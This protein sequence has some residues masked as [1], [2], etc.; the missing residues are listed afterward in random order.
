MAELP[1][2]NCDGVTAKG[3][4]SDLLHAFQLQGRTWCYSDLADDGGFSV[5]PNDAVLVHA[6]VHGSIR[7]VRAGQPPL[8]VDAG[9]AV[10]VLSGEAHALRTAV[11]A[12]ADGHGYLRKE[13]NADIPASFS[14][15]Q[16]RRYCARVLSGRMRPTWPD[17]LSRSTLPPLLHLGTGGENTTGTVTPAALVRYGFGDGSPVVL[18]QLASFLLIEA[19]RQTRLRGNSISPAQS[20]PIEEA[21]QAIR[22]SPGN[23]WTV[24]QLAQRVGMRRSNFSAQ[25]TARIGRPP[26]EFVTQARMEKAA[27]LLCRSQMAIADIGEAIGYSCEAAFVR[28]FT[29]YFSVAPTHMRATEASA[30]PDESVSPVPLAILKGARNTEARMVRHAVRDPDNR[31]PYDPLGSSNM[32]LR[33]R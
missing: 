10:A 29:R 8:R 23:D 27:E 21:V 14:F 11:D 28:R 3:S 26:M 1:A 19:L 6:V 9:Q 33:A 16:S 30:R 15:G 18:T 25:F 20:D 12:S 32:I 7:L 2:R 5:P 24:L 4:V 13:Q 31:Q 22:L 17:G